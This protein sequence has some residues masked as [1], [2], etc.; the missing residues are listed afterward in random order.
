MAFFYESDDEHGLGGLPIILEPDNE[1]NPSPM[2]RSSF[3]DSKFHRPNYDGASYKGE[4]DSEYGYGH[5][6]D[7][8]SQ[9]NGA[10]YE[11]TSDMLR[12]N[13][14]RYN[15]TEA[16]QLTEPSYDDIS[17]RTSRE[18]EDTMKEVGVPFDTMKEV[19]IESLPPRSA[20]S[21]AAQVQVHVPTHPIASMQDAFAESM[22]EVSGGI[23]SESTI[24]VGSAALRRKR[25]LDQDINEETH[26]SRWRQKPGQQYHEL[27]KLMAQIS[28]GMYLLLNGLAKDDDQVM[29]ILQGHVD[30]V[31]EFLETTLED[32]DLADG[33]IEER[34]DLLKMPL[35]NIK[36]FDA[37]LED[38]NFRVQIVNGNE[39]IEHV[40]TR[41]AKAM[42]DALKD[43][44]QGL[45]ACKEFTIYLA[46]EQ[47]VA[48]WRRERPD[49]QK[50]FD[51]MKGNVEGWYKAYVSLQTKGNNLGV[52]LVQLGTIVA[53]MD[54]RAGDISRRQARLSGSLS[55][56]P[57][58]LSPRASKQM[59]QSM[60]RSL[61]PD[62][63]VITPAIKATLPA[64][65]MVDDRER[66][67]GPEPGLWQELDAQSF[68]PT[69]NESS[70]PSE[71]AAPEPEFILKPHT[72]TPVSSP[73]PPSAIRASAPSPVIGKALEPSPPK[74]KISLRKR[75]SLKRKTSEMTIKAPPILS[76]DGL[77]SPRQSVRSGQS[78]SGSALR[79]RENIVDT[80][81]SRGL[82]SAYCSDVEKKEKKSPYSGWNH[83]AL[84]R[85]PPTN[86]P[87]MVNIPARQASHDTLPTLTRDFMPSPRSDQQFFRPVQA[88]PNSPLQ[89]PWTAAPANID[90][91]HS[92]SSSSNLRFGATPTQSNLG[93][94]RGAPSAMGMSVMTDMTMMTEN[95]K[96]VK[97][98]RSAL[99]WLKKQFSLS[100]EEKAAFEERKRG[101][102]QNH[103]QQER[104]QQR[105]LDGKRIR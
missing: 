23:T 79:E 90:R 82:D 50:V 4:S 93:T 100:E 104:G 66:S 76:N 55:S 43:V 29:N 17:S 41:T 13:A 28:F 81:P 61:P 88:S 52:A 92:N 30:E 34:L 40:I 68:V 57:P 75:F 58:S 59:R 105:W 65:G 8:E 25:L 97:K 87:R 86:L 42:N 84:I 83:P 3:E 38:R 98:K 45:D 69:E 60:L 49:M 12:L 36:I 14:S 91:L 102:D 80:P 78:P 56:S 51:A 21:P 32:F 10:T 72:Y 39:R 7:E 1:S 35:E 53:E 6:E 64:F 54:K 62:P 77:L 96:K 24:K 85:T 11:D 63:T 46:K 101:A 22:V 9:L 103:Y 33:D 26:A 47:E 37:M 19:H 73:K 18:H 67:P 27:W 44:T 99:G 20:P 31:D 5:E 95:G 15:G 89:R 74:P 2:R 70:A 94:R 48:V 71:L 16:S